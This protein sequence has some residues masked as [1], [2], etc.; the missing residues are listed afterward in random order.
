MVSD[1]SKEI[2]MHVVHAYER[3]E[4][5]HDRAKLHGLPS[6]NINFTLYGNKRHDFVYLRTIFD[7]AARAVADPCRHCPQMKFCA[8][9]LPL[10]ENQF[11]ADIS[12]DMSCTLAGYETC[13]RD[14]RHL[15][16]TSAG[17]GDVPSCVQHAVG[18]W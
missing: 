11:Q 3:V 1:L 8:T 4:S 10:K 7:A 6:R 16:K 14:T 12:V 5:N 9:Y 13:T 17:A 18:E 2:A 15:R